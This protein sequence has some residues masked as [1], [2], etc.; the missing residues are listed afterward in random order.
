MEA[1]QRD[2][3]IESE[4]VRPFLCDTNPFSVAVS[5]CFV[6][7]GA[8]LK[9]FNANEV[10]RQEAVRQSIFFF[11]LSSFFFSLKMETAHSNGY[12]EKYVTKKNMYNQN[13]VVHYSC[14]VSYGHVEMSEIVC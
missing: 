8:N 14:H 11:F 13:H 2:R 3:E 6:P 12:S 9:H 5:M 7:I 10:C 1:R 4:K